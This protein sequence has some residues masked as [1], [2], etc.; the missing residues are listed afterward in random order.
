MDGKGDEVKSCFSRRD[1]AAILV[2]SSLP[3][4]EC[5][6][7]AGG[8]LALPISVFGRHRCILATFYSGK[9]TAFGKG[10]ITPT[11]RTPLY[12]PES[13]R[14]GRTRRKPTGPPARPVARS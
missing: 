9:T 14:V 7:G 10:R 13:A 2:P 5:P 4:P 11:E 3:R 6:N 8:I 12:L 1:A